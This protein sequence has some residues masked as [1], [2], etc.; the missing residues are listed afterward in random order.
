MGRNKQVFHVTGKRP[1]NPF[2][3]G[4]V[5]WSPVSAGFPILPDEVVHEQIG[6]VVA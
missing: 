6:A 5:V 3:S 4:S 1:T 2:S